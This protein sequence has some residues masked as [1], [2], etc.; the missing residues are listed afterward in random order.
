MD[1]ELDGEEVHDREAE[2]HAPEDGVGP[3]E[4]T[5]G[6][7]QNGYDEEEDQ[8]TVHEDVVMES[9][10]F[11]TVSQNLCTILDYQC[12][13]STKQASMIQLILRLV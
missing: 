3:D 1:E 13:A 11:A 6:K 4:G 12:R 5:V 10:N 9:T 8:H 2:D 7:G